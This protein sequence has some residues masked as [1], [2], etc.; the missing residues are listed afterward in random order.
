MAEFVLPGPL[1]DFERIHE[2]HLCVE[3]FIANSAT[4]HEFVAD[5]RCEIGLAVAD[6]TAGGG[7]TLQEIPF[8]DDEVVLA[9]PEGYAWAA[10][11]EVELEDLVRMPMVMR[12]PGAS[13]RQTVESALAAQGLS[14]ASPLA[15]VGSTSAAKA[16]ALSE[17]APLPA[18]GTGRR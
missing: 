7:E 5:G 3:L 2:H 13:S 11:E 1:V 4:I 17:R 10:A 12:D 6:S 15:E 14:L 18:C 16:T 8:V 9:V